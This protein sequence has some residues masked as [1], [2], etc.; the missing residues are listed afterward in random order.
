M[1]TGAS[2]T[3]SGAGTLALFY[4]PISIIA[5]ILAFLPFAAA[6]SLTQVN[7]SVYPTLPVGALPI[8]WTQASLTTTSTDTTNLDLGPCPCDLTWAAC[9]L[10]CCCDPDCA[11]LADSAY[12]LGG[13]LRIPGDNPLVPV[14]SSLLVR[15]N[16]PDVEAAA[17]AQTVASYAGG[18][19]V[20]KQNSP[21]KGF[22]YSDP[23]TVYQSQNYFAE[24]FQL[25]EFSYA[26]PSYSVDYQYPS[27]TSLAPLAASRPYQMGDFVIV[28]YTGVTPEAGVLFLPAPTFSGFCDDGNPA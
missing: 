26:A 9:D 7:V 21:L 27:D 22:Y 25:N 6:E 11:P 18:L 15:I 24:V 1:S 19:C 5:I 8:N 28:Q 20:Y 4:P 12:A 23:G 13:C 17:T 14:C 3:D 2:A 10:G 16:N